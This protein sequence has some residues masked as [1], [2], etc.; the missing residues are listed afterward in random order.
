MEKKGDVCLLKE[1]YEKIVELTEK[2]PSAHWKD[3]WMCI[4]KEIDMLNCLSRESRDKRFTDRKYMYHIQDIKESVYFTDISKEKSNKEA[5]ARANKKKGIVDVEQFLD[6]NYND[7]G[8]EVS[9]KV[10]IPRVVDYLLHTFKFKTIYGS[11][12]ELIYFYN[13]G[14][15]KKQ[16]REKIQFE[17]EKLLHEYCNNHIVRESEEKIK[18]RTQIPQE[19]F[20]TIPEDLICLEN[21]I[22]NI[23]TKELQ[24]HSHEFYFKTKIPVYYDEK[25]DC[26]KIKNFFEE[27]FYPEDVPVIQEW[28]GFNLYRKYFIK[29]AMIVFGD[30]D[31]GKTVFLNLMVNFIGNA[32]KTGI[33][34]QRISAGDKFAIADLKDKYSNIFD[35]L[36]SKDLEAG[37]FKVAIGGG[38]ITGEEKF[39]DPKQFL[40]FAKHTFAANKIPS[41]KSIDT[42]DDAYYNRW[43]PIACDNS[44]SK[45]EQDKFLV[46]KLS[47]VEEMSGLLNYALQG[48]HRLLENGSFTFNKTSQQIRQMME[49]HGNPLAA[50]AQDC[51]VNKAGYKLD[52]E[53]LYELYHTYLLEKGGAL[54]SVEQVSR[55]LPRHAKYII[56]KHGGKKRYWE[57]VDCNFSRLVCSQDTLDTLNLIYNHGNKVNESNSIL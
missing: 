9:R 30:T 34:L 11:H 14:I 18:R 19:E 28:L 20:D 23:K 35:D 29:K 33:N 38:Y 57:N 6:I 5:V 15:Y 42:D 55:R 31:T 24:K 1:D 7:E 41:I 53:V 21:G 27:T 36:S 50:F 54:L 12:S 48:L 32:N 17:I 43:L 47:D 8:K 16:G 2:Y 25:A 4:N 22:F 3:I 13:K 40:N 52:K 46:E 39:G 44:V 56:A 45:G 37:G 26:P 49:K 10:N 51:L